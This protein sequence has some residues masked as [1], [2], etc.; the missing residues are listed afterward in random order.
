[1]S[2]KCRACDIQVPDD[3]YMKCSKKQCEKVYDLKCLGLTQKEGSP[4]S[5]ENLSKQ[6]ICPECVCSKP[7]PIRYDPDNTPLRNTPELKAFTPSA[8]VNTQRGSR[9]KLMDKSDVECDNC[10]DSW[11][12]EFR[13]FRNEIISRLDV[14]TSIIK[15]LQ[16]VCFSTKMELEELKM[17]MKVRQHK[18]TETDQNQRSESIDSSLESL[19]A[20]VQVIDQI[21]VPTTFADVTRISINNLNRK[22][23]TPRVSKKREATKTADGRESVVRSQLINQPQPH[24]SPKNNSNNSKEEENN[25]KDNEWTTVRKK[26][27][28]FQSKNV[29]K[30][31]NMDLKDIQ[32]TEKKRHLHVWR[33]NKETTI[34]KLISHVKGVCGLDANVKIEKIKHKTERDYA[35]FI[36]TVSESMYEKLCQS[37]VWLVNTEFCEWIWFRKTTYK[38]TKEKY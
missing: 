24:M 2:L 28:S 38:P 6:W 16:E 10:E 12:S 18:I 15:H 22:N 35:S 34:E 7:K 17:N 5:D 13:Q 37:E 32:A 19:N 8:N 20:D 26:R 21:D 23:T 29:K 4:S 3:G 27:G 25:N 30:G 1:M 14:Q 33:L 36:V 9:I 11:L 31:N